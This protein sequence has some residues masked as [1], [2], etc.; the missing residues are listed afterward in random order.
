MD[1]V[2]ASQ[3]AVVAALLTATCAAPGPQARDEHVNR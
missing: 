1:R 3:F 2:K